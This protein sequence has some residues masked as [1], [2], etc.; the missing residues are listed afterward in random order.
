MEQ[1]Q[2]GEINIAL[3]HHPVL[4]RNNE[5]IGSAVTNLD[6]H[7]IARTAKTYGIHNNYIVTPY[8][9][10]QQLVGEIIDHWQ[11]GHGSTYNPARREAFELVRMAGSLEEV[12][13]SFRQRRGQDPALVTTSA[14]DQ[15]KTL[16]YSNSRKRMATGESTL[17][18]F[19]TA[20][21]LASE[22][23]AKADYT[24]PAIIGRTG[25]NHLS[26]RA[27]VA[28]ICDRLFGESIDQEE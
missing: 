4:G 8:N 25:Y 26:V 10:Q 21:G 2:Q 19:G 6:I 24:L 14:F 20:H 27:A 1:Q 9:D 22:V 28:I 3:I 16:S 15:E 23:V 18:I 11:N 13:E 5:T 17:L 12:V 7:D